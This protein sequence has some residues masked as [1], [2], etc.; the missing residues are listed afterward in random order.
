LPYPLFAIALRKAIPAPLLGGT[1]ELALE[2]GVADKQALSL[3]CCAEV[4]MRKK[5]SSSH[6]S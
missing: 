3:F 1:V 4:Q 2:V 6:L 5:F